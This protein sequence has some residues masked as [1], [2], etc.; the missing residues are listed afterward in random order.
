MK[1]KT[2]V[3]RITHEM[4]NKPGKAIHIGAVGACKRKGFTR[5]QEYKKSNPNIIGI[6]DKA[7]LVK[8]AHNK[9]HKEIF[10]ADITNKEQV[11]KIIEKH[12]TFEHLILTEVIE[13]VG[14]L[15]M[16]FDNIYSMMTDTSQL[17]I[18]TPNIRSDYVIKYWQSQ[19]R[20]K[21]NNDHIAW[22]CIKTITTLLK[23]SNL[24]IVH[25]REYKKSLFVIAKRSDKC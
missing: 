18:S 24:T 23:R 8:R 17:Y 14:N 16:M 20:Y 21:V 1:F 2:Y 25:S 3:H 22:F 10:V 19:Q 6:D 13:H 15:T 9:G 5:H 12:G 4:K 7:K 11:N